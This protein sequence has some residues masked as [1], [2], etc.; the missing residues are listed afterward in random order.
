MDHGAVDGLADEAVLQSE[1]ESS[2]ATYG[3]HAHDITAELGKIHERLRALE[4]QTGTCFMFFAFN[5]TFGIQNEYVST[6][7]LSYPELKSKAEDAILAFRQTAGDTGAL[8]TKD[9]S[10]AEDKKDMPLDAESGMPPS[11]QGY[12]TLGVSAADSSRRYGSLEIRSAIEGE[13]LGRL[14]FGDKERRRGQGKW[15]FSWMWEIQDVDEFF[16]GLRFKAARKM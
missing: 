15:N 11:S 12:H 16:R 7:L 1:R 2:H 5:S 9:Q 8:N 6:P 4:N 14:G 13:T 10:A 3:L